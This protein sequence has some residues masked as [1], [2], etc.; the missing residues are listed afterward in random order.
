V[1]LSASLRRS[2]FIV[3]VSGRSETMK[4][5]AV[6]CRPPRPSMR[7]EELL[8]GRLHVGLEDDGESR[9]LALLSSGRRSD[10]ARDGRVIG[11]RVLDVGRRDGVARDLEDV[12]W[13][14]RRSGRGRS[15]RAGEVAGLEPL[16]LVAE[17]DAR[18]LDP[19]LAVSP[20]SPRCRRRRRR[21]LWTERR[22]MPRKPPRI[23]AGG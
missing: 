6:A 23:D 9:R 12:L 2:T 17:H 15:A 8:L 13:R 19:E 21:A 11:E 20:P 4:T 10:G 7:G 3:D 22:G 1:N 16:A 14:G 18:A 5:A